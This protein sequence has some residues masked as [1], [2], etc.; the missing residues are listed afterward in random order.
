[1]APTIKPPIKKGTVELNEDTEKL[2]KIEIVNRLSGKT[3][4]SQ[5]KRKKPA[6]RI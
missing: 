6:F 3:P 5:P 1:M 4:V 2:V